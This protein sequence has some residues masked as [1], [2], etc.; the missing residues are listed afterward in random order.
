[1]LLGE[2][3]RVGSDRVTVR[4]QYEVRAGDGVVFE[5]DRAEGTEQGGRVYGVFRNGIRCE[6]AEDSGVV[7]LTFDR[8]SIDFRC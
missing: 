3:I 4:L 5:G 1:M 7:E 6:D 8:K 2:V